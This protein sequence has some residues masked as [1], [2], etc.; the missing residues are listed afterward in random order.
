MNTQI[1]LANV[2]RCHFSCRA[3]D[4]REYLMIILLITRRSHMQNKKLSLIITKYSLLS[5][6]Q[7]MAL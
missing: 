1:V 7:L 3:L 5:R 4:K 6:A 2:V